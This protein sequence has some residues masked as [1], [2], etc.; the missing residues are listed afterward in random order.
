MLTDE[1]KKWIDERLETTETKLLTAFHEWAQVNDKRVHSH[2]D[3]ISA[4][5]MEIALLRRRMDKLEG[6]K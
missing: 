4:V 1:D 6:R 3:A 2:T 5:E